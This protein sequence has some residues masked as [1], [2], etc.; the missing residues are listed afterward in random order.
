MNISLDGLNQQKIIDK[1]IKQENLL[2]SEK[3]KKLQNSTNKIRKL[4]FWDQPIV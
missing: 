2:L 4:D 1:K 3:E